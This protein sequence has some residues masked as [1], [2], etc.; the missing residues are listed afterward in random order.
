MLR[1]LLNA[2]GK[3]TDGKKSEKKIYIKQIPPGITEGGEEWFSVGFG[4]NPQL[5]KKAPNN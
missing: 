2:V 3:Q 5:L 4:Q 1:S